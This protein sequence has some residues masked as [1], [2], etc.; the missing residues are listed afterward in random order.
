[1]KKENITY[2]VL[3]IILGGLLFISTDYPVYNSKMKKAKLI[4]G[5]S[6]YSEV[7]IDIVG[8]IK[9]ITCDDG[10][11]YI[12]SKLNGSKHER[13]TEERSK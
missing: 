11:T 13:K 1:M 4:C 2:F 10:K 8:Q 9:K 12:I 7:R 3:G 6:D 5:D